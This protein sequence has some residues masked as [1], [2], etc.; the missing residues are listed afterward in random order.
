MRTIIW[1]P[2]ALED[3]E[4]HIDYINDRSPIGAELVVTRLSDAVLLL[5]DMPTG[6]PGKVPGTYERYIRKTSLIIAFELVDTDRLVILRVIHTARD[7][8]DGHWPKE[9]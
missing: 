6:R 4:A 2:R 8:P 1:A 5:R 3:V 7:W 9:D